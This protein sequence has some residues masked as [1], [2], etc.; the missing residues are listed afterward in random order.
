MTIDKIYFIITL[1]LNILIVGKLGCGKSATGNTICGAQEFKSQFSG[2]STT[3]D[4]QNVSCLQESVKR[5]ISVVDTPTL[6]EIQDEEV[7]LHHKITE[8]FHQDADKSFHVILLVIA[9]GRFTDEDDKTVSLFMENFGEVAELC[10]I[11]VFSHQDQLGT[12]IEEFL[13]PVPEVLDCYF[14]RFDQ[15]YIGFNNK[16]KDTKQIKR[17]FDVIDDMM[18]KNGHKKY[19]SKAFKEAQRKLNSKLVDRGPVYKLDEKTKAQLRNQS[20]NE[21]EQK[22]VEEKLQLK[23]I[24]NS[25]EQEMHFEYNREYQHNEV[26][27][28]KILVAALDIGTSNS[29]YAYSSV[30]D[31]QI[32][33]LKI[34]INQPSVEMRTVTTRMPT[35][36]LLDSNREF[37]S[38]GSGAEE[39]Y[40][41]YSLD[42]T[43]DYYYFNGS[44]M[45]LHDNQN[46]NDQME[47]KDVTGKSVS[48]IK[49]FGFIIKELKMHLID[50]LE[51]QP[52]EIEVREIQ[53][54]LTVP[55]IWS[56]AAK[57]LMRKSAIWAGIPDDC[58]KL[59]L[60]PEAASI[61]YQ[62]LAIGK[63]DITNLD[64]SIAKPGAKYML[65]DLGGGTV[66]ITV[67]EKG[68]DKKLKQLCRATGN[69]C[70][71]NAVNE[72]FL[73]MFDEIFGNT[74]MKSLKEKLPGEYLDLVRDF[75]YKKRTVKYREKVTIRIPNQYLNAHCIAA[76]SKDLKSCVY[77][78]SY[79]KYISLL[80]DKMRI[81]YFIFESLF[82][83]TTE[84]IT[85][86]IR[87]SLKRKA[88]S[89]VSTILLVGEFSNSH[90][91]RDAIA[92][93]FTNQ[94][95][96][97]PEEADLCILKGS[98][99]FGHKQDYI[100]S[101]V[102]QFSYGIGEMFDPEKLDKKQPRVTPKPNKCRNIFSQIVERG[103]EV[104]TSKKFT[105]H[106]SIVDAEQLKIKLYAS[107]EKSPTFTDEEKCSFVGTITIPLT[108]G[109]RKIMLEYLFGDTEIDVTAFDVLT[110]TQL[111]SSFDF[112]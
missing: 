39:K 91:I 34:H 52:Y 93:E 59:A 13:N 74:V 108:G 41:E 102:V 62:Y 55:S 4:C 65:V 80:G 67:H 47:V 71:G 10:T 89:R 26:S 6:F 98:V 35:N 107:T 32:D 66:D 111:P 104:E 38:F 76:Y 88:V 43:S 99:L 101:R 24:Q 90:L 64:N 31:F 16:S 36:L 112:V 8:L 37:V 60:E 20:R 57:Q 105:T 70:G 82:K 96:I 12:H 58:L 92:Q 50:T 86:L 3:T 94:C 110:H 75:E 27:V 30:N 29:G 19:T 73:Q 2:E 51:K 54:V 61:F 1:E 83:P 69:D 109:E 87:V 97:V 56:D 25:L 9:A 81:D 68:K 28:E 106:H 18:S 79:G 49:I 42:E 85:S 7:K 103:Q 44:K 84:K 77:S 45:V 95:V 11:I 17:C 46:I 48:A 5:K 33:P 100:C 63:Q 14:D 78:S 53:W 40:C 72:K 23:R 22:F 15:R 21:I